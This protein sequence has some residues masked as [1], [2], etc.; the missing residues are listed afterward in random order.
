MPMLCP[1]GFNSCK[2]LLADRERYRKN[3]TDVRLPEAALVA[4][5][6]Y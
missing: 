4:S 5:Y 1:G 2:V 3:N 6:T